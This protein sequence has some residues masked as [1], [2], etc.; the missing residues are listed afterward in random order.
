VEIPT[1]TDAA[2]IREQFVAALVAGDAN[3][4]EIVALDAISQGMPVADLYVDVIGAAL[5][6]V[7]HRWEQR[8][9]SIAEEHLATGIAHDVMR[10]LSRTATRY[11]RRSRERVL[12]GAIG[13]EAHVTGLRMVGDLAE[14]DG[15]DVRYLGAQVPV[16]ELTGIVAKHTPEIVGLSVTMA[17]T[18]A[19]VS[20]A[21]SAIEASG[22]RPRAILLGGRG[23]TDAMRADPRV[24][25]AADA[26]EA[27]SIIE[28]AAD[29]V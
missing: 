28:S 26:R 24:R 11:P 1:G 29:P 23:V 12:L 19:E 20:A 9:M 18:A 21:L 8:R 13:G 17:G 22:H 5:A 6:E 14:G 3:L 16:P 10:L 27:M 25:Y 2:A 15:F 4:A 7:G